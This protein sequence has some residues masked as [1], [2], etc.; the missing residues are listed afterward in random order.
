MQ[1]TTIS[2]LQFFSC[3]LL[4]HSSF[5][6]DLILLSLAHLRTLTQST[7]PALSGSLTL[8]ALINR[9]IELGHL[10]LLPHRFSTLSVHM[11]RINYCIKHVKWPV[12]YSYYTTLKSIKYQQL[13]IKWR[14]T[15]LVKITTDWPVVIPLTWSCDIWNLGHRCPSNGWLDIARHLKLRMTVQ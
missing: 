15:N 10:F 14:D 11:G 6:L 7:W 8:A 5:A 13:I 9:I 4:S 2:F 3:C 1:P 12:F